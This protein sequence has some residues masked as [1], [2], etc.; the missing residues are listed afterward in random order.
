M[1]VEAAEIY[2]RNE[3]ALH[4]RTLNAVTESTKEKGGLVIAPSS[5][6]DV[7]SSLDKFAK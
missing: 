7:F 2:E 1:Y 4:L 3:K 6:G 5:I